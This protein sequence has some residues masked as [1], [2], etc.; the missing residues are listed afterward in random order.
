MARSQIRF[1]FKHSSIYGL[2]TVFG[3]AAGF[4]LLPLYTRYLSPTDYGV[5]ALVETTVSLIGMVASLGVAQSI[6][7]F[8]SAAEDQP[9][10]NLVISTSYWASWIITLI[11]FPVLYYLSEPLSQLIFGNSL[12]GLFFKISSLALFIGMNVEIGL[13]Y[14]MM[15]ARSSRYVTL[16]VLSTLLLIGFNIYFIVFKGMGLLGIFY[17]TLI[18]RVLFSLVISIPVLW[19]VRL[20][21]ELVKALEM[22]RFSVP[23]VFSSVFRMLTNESDKYFINFYFSPFETGIYAIAAKI[24]TS[25][26]LLITSPFLQSFNAV[27]F[28]IQKQENGPRVY[29]SILEYYLVAIGSVGLLVSVFSSEVIRLMTTERFYSAAACI[30]PLVLSWIFFGMKYHFEN[31]IM[32]MM[33]TRYISYISGVSAGANLLLNFLL[34]P[35]YGLWGAVLSVNF[36][37]LTMAGLSFVFSQ[38]LYAM[39]VEW[40]RI[41]KLTLALALTF[42]ASLLVTG[43]ELYASLMLKTGLFLAYF[44]SLFA[45]RIVDPYML[46]SLG[47][48]F[49]TRERVQSP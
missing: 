22:I 21:W 9:A 49:L 13:T 25:V 35:R 45:L 33:K 44:A 42:G 38:K 43:L 34:I 3:Q 14:H 4:L 36:S 47:R 40:A 1:L 48:I 12:Y 39:H 17:S 26:H 20:R 15:K 24:A 6:A 37:Y 19:E 23:L 30:P 5:A 11:C 46:Q 29:G 31:G 27:R 2:G 41:V 18:N 16:S 32:I 10:K 7:R 8:Y 28:E